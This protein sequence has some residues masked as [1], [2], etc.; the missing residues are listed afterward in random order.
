MKVVSLRPPS[1]IKLTGLQRGQQ[2][3]SPGVAVTRPG[4][5]QSIVKERRNPLWFCI[6]YRSASLGNNLGLTL[7]IF[8]TSTASE[9]E[10]PWAFLSLLGGLFVGNL[11]QSEI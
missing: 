3:T 1:Q 5:Q 2:D 9:S 10:S 4:N 7:Y 8:D 6:C 11:C